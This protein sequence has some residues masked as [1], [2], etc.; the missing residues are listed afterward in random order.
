VKSRL[1][2]KDKPESIHD[3]HIR[4]E[5]ERTN[6]RMRHFRGVSASVMND[7]LKLW[8]E[9]WEACQDPRTEIE[10]IE[11][12]SERKGPIPAC[13]WQEFREKLHLLGHYIDYTKRLCEGSI[14]D[15]SKKESEV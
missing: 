10:I 15:T 6:A 13:G 4:R 11:G 2:S 8:Q 7:A 1:K 9:I 12:A 3:E 5:I 14:D